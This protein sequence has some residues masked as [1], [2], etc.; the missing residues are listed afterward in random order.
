MKKEAQACGK[1]VQRVRAER[2]QVL[3]PPK[4]PPKTAKEQRATY[5]ARV[6]ASKAQAGAVQASPSLLTAPISQVH[7]KHSKTA[8][9]LKPQ[10]V[11]FKHFLTPPFDRTQIRSPPLEL[12]DSEPRP[13]AQ[14]RS[15]GNE[16][17]QDTHLSVVEPITAKSLKHIEQLLAPSHAE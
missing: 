16:P 7:Q 15:E 10:L 8:S 11:P 2:L 1:R 13:I 5:K 9:R 4:P 6:R 14:V 17:Q 3:K 12:E